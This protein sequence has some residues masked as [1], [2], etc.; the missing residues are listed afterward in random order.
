MHR[1]SLT[2]LRWRLRGAWQW[3][4]FV[5]LTAVEGVTLNALPISGRGPGGV[6]PGLLLATGLNLI[7]VAGLAPLTARLV[8]RRRPDLP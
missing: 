3:P 6:V 8:R 1:V 2:R 5:A 4:V 7:V